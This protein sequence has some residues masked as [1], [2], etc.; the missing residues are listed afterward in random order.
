MPGNRLNGDTVPVSQPEL[1]VVVPCYNEAESLPELCRRLAEAFP[2][3]DSLT[4]EFVLVDDGSTDGTAAVLQRLAADDP[5]IVPLPRPTRGGQT[6]ALWDG[7][8][9]ARGRWIA[10]LDGDLQNDPA[11]LPVM[12]RQAGQENL[13]AV[14]GYRESRHDDF[15]RRFASRFANSVRRLVLHDTIRDIGCSTRVVRREILARLEPVP[16]LHRYLPAL[17]EKGNWRLRQVPVH[18]YERDF[19]VSKYGNLSRGLQGL[20]DLPRMA[21][22]IRA[23]EQDAT[24]RVES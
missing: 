5:R 8:Q 14:L 18:H 2:T 13:D 1:S 16:N 24:E 7:L 21:A 9:A 23:L 20:R 12:L 6:M 15:G 22:Y 4:V 19:G 11:D 17:I 3:D 10:H